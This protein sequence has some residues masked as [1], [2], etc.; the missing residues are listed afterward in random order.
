MSLF[1]KKNVHVTVMKPKG[2][3]GR[4]CYERGG[5]HSSGA[6]VQ[7]DERSKKRRGGRCGGRAYSWSLAGHGCCTS[8]LGVVR[9]APSWRWQVKAAAAQWRAC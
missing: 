3:H 6:L 2:Y 4:G 5:A 8:R 7:T 1:F 9:Y